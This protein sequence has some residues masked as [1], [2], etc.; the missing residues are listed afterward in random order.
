MQ[1]VQDI[2]DFWFLPEVHAEYGQPRKAW[3]EKNP[4]F[5]A[6]IREKFLADFE[7]AVEGRFLSWTDRAKGSLALILLFDQFTRNMFRDDPRAFSADGK[8]REIARHMLRSGQYEELVPFMRQFAALPFEHS[9][10]LADQ[11][12]SMQLFTAMNDA[13]LIRYA[14]A[15]YDIIEKFGRFPHRNKTLGRTSTSTEEAF[16]KEPNSSF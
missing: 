11:K 2:L 4:E 14:K 16:L 1:R 12:R 13:E 15:H 3:F 10:D 7:Q 8:A 5:D 6:E 9:E